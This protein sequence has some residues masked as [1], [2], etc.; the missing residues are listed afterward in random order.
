M[1]LISRAS[2]L[3]QTNL[4]LLEP[5][6]RLATTSA[7]PEEKKAP[8][9]KKFAI[10]RWDPEQPGQKPYLKE[11]EVDLNDCGMMVLDALVKIK[12]EQDSTLAFRRSCREGICGSCSMN[13]NGTNTLACLCKIDESLS[14]KTKIYPLPHM[15]VIKDLIPDLSNFYAQYKSI[16]PYLKRKGEIKVGEQ[17]FYQS[18]EDRAKLDG[19]Y[20]CILCACCS[21]S[22]PSYWWNSDK[23]LGPAVL[24]QS[25]RW[26]IDSRDQFAKERLDKFRDE[27]SVYRC[28]TIMNCTTVCPKG[29]N[30]GQAIAEIKKLMSGLWKEPSKNASVIPA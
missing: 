8:R 23:Y 30:P 12:N 6:V 17:Q 20:E 22:C 14:K 9:M 28:H 18:V 26:I 21:T 24:L 13:I 16:E 15:F 10:Y 1:A 4:R 2:A 3:L 27:F 11:Y 5:V 29:L 25:Y 19:L 7:V